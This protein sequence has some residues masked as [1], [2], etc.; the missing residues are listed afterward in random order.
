MYQVSQ[1]PVLRPIRP[2][3]VLSEN[4]LLP[5]M[6][7]SLIFAASPS[8][9]VKT[10]LTRLRSSG[11]IVVVTSAPYRLFVRY[12]RLIS[13]S[14]RSTNARSNGRPSPMPESFSALDSVSL[15]NSF[16]PT[17][18]TLAMIERSSTITTTTLPSISM[19]TSLNRPVA[20]SARNAAAPFSSL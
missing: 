2:S 6:R 16:K 13:C 1:P 7:M 4:A 17:K 14:A 10:T 18:L 15:S 12:W 20:N 9:I 8:L 3:S 5:T 19:R 11:V